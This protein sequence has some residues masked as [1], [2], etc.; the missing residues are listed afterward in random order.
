MS[1]FQAF[2]NTYEYIVSTANQ[3]IPAVFVI[4]PIIFAAV[5]LRIYLRWKHKNQRRR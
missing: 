1:L 5:M 3:R 2:E 4:L